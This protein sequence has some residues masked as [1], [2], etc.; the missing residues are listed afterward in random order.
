M[1]CE[2]A[3]RL[4]EHG[5]RYADGEPEAQQEGKDK[6]DKIIYTVLGSYRW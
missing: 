2:D 6:K 5:T 1:A 3:R 4:R